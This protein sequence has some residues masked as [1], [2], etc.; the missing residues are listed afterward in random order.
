MNTRTTFAHDHSTVKDN[1][2]FILSHFE[3]QHEMFPR[4]TETFKTRGQVK[5][6]YESDVMVSKRKVLDYFR[7][8][9]FVDCKINAFWLCSL[10]GIL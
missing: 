3:G 2:D 6:E 7:Q 4:T 10:N 9:G 8:A 5:I 1:T